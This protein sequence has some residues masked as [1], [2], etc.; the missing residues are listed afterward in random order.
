MKIYFNLLLAVLCTSFI[1]AGCSHD[2]SAP[3]QSP[4]LFKLNVTHSMKGWEL[5]SWP[6]G[7][8]WKFSFLMGTD[9][10]KSFLEVTSSNGTGA[11]IRVAGVDS[12]KMVL[13]Q[14]PQGEAITL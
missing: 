2:Y 7:N 1:V 5:Y 13:N 14:F 4:D 6:E 10:L 11:L 8:T 3:S 12:A 9:R